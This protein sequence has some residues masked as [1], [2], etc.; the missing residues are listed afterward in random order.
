MLGTELSYVRERLVKCSKEER[1]QL[2]HMIGAHPKTLKRI[3]ERYT[4]APRSD[5]VGKLAMHF[6][7]REKREGA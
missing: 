4:K 7:T 1:D 2:A 3:A 6:R 5:I